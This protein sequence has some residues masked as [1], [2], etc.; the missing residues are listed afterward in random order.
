MMQPYKIQFKEKHIQIESN[1]AGHCGAPKGV[2][3]IEIM[4]H[5]GTRSLR[6]SPAGR[7]TTQMKSFYDA[8]T[9]PNHKKIGRLI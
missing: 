8:I 3:I 1:G 4:H 6:L 9:V 7:T 2:V 5:K